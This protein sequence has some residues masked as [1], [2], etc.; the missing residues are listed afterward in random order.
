[1]A[2]RNR[3]SRPDFLKVVKFIEDKEVDSSLYRSDDLAG[4]IENNTGVTLS[5][6]Q[7]RDLYRDA[8]LEWRVIGSKTLDGSTRRRTVKYRMDE[9]EPKVAA[10]EERVST[11]EGLAKRTTAVARFPGLIN[12]GSE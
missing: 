11:L 6:V 1:M 7:L 5:P 9:L 10:L 12:D 4:L 3:L 8:D 2:Q